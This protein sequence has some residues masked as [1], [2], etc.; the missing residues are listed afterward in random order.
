MRKILA[1]IL[2][3]CALTASA[4]EEWYI[5]KP[6]K[7]FTFTGL[8]SVAANE[9]TALVQ[10]YI[11]R[12]FSLELFWEIQE[13]LYALDYFESIESNALPADG[14]TAVIV[15]FVVKEK[16][17]VADIVLEGNRQ[18]RRAE[19]LEKVLIKKGDLVTQAQVN[20]DTDAIAALYVEKGFTEASVTGS[21]EAGK[22]GNT[23]EVRFRIVEGVQ[24]AI[25]A[26]AFSGNS[27][28]SESTLRRLMKTKPQS[29]FSS[30]LFQEAKLEEDLAGILEYYGEHGF[31]DA[32]I[33]KVDRAVERDDKEGKN[34]LTIT[35]YLAEGEQW[36]YGGMSFEGN[37]IFSTEQL[38][39]L[40][41]QTPGKLLDKSRLEA[42][43]QRVADLY[44]ENGYIFNSIGR[45][46]VRD[47]Q[48]KEIAYTIR[49]LEKDRAHIES[50][51]LK[52]NTKTKDYVILRELPFEEGDIF[53]KA[54]V[55][56]GL[57]NLYNLQYFTSVQPETPEGSVEGLMDLVIN[58]EEG[59]TANINFGVTFSG[60]DYPISGV[61]KW[62]ENNFL[63]RGQAV[64]VNLEIS[65]LRQMAALSFTEPWLFGKR[66]SGGVNLS[67]EHALVPNIYQDIDGPLFNGD[68]D[69]A[70]PDPFDGHLVNPDDGSPG[71][72]GDDAITDYEYA[73][74]NG[75]SIPDQYTMDYTTWKFAAGLE[76]GYRAFTPLGW[77]GVRGGLSVA[78]EK[79]EYDP[80]LYRPFD[81]VIRSGQGIWQNINKLGLT[82]FWDKRDYF[83]NPS[84]GFYLAQGITFAL[85][86]PVGRREYTR[87]DT[88]LEGFLTLVD[89]QATENWKLR[90]I[91]AAHS[92]L[93]FILPP[94]WEFNATG[95]AKTITND[96]L[97]IDGWNIARGWPLERDLFALWDNRLE[98]RVPIAEQLLWGVFFFDAVAGYEE[99]NGLRDLQLDDFLFS[100]GGGIRFSI[101][102]FPIRLYL[103]KR[104]KR[105]GGEWQWQEGDLPF[106]GG[107][108]DFVIS[109]GGDTF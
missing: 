48:K 6:I 31:V 59:S 78:L 64:G 75:Y 69:F 57:R 99:A 91:L 9:L 3:F 52:G 84:K 1:G 94:F 80:A 56:Q 10:P 43:T 106:F 29:L 17:S 81:P 20:A 13:K 21:L 61:L 82:L 46:E 70:V 85:G 88:T 38:A 103:A 72:T 15:E 28:A 36:V 18:L 90:L 22:E 73:I 105:T 108:V 97:Y 53:S 92:S 19:I 71:Y 39:E 107:S 2:L 34:F 35:I 24:T 26:I 44:Y 30:G 16:P 33:D 4:Q 76:S 23:V 60:G 86:L 68:E 67:F 27:F 65:N 14:E 41:R 32:R 55:V 100:F 40:V 54:K 50:I 42:D 77:L 66:W 95:D 79:I 101:P 7:S 45:D 109:L 25:R 47:E 98:L 63:G 93:H 96:R 51:E 87:T 37:Q 49:I 58:V 74:N 11:D 104:F 89:W 5:G 62:S 12:D 8:E 102:Q 83:L